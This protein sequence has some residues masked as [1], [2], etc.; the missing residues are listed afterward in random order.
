MSEVEQQLEQILEQLV[1]D[2]EASV[3]AIYRGDVRQQ[4]QKGK[5]DTHKRAAREALLPMLARPQ[6]QG[7]GIPA[8]A[9]STGFSPDEVASITRCVMGWGAM[10]VPAT[11][12]PQS[13]CVPA[14]KELHPSW[15]EREKAR[16]SM[17]RASA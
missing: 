7:S 14:A 12:S 11:A 13:R 9:P 5:T 2:I 4:T 6:H 1:R 15:G 17:K 3:H 8:A 16:L 10:G